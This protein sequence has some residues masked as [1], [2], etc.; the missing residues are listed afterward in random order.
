MPTVDSAIVAG[1]P[2]KRKPGRPPRTGWE[3]RYLKILAERG[4]TYL[5]AQ[6]AG[7]SHHTVQYRR[8][9][10]PEFVAAERD[11]IQLFAD[12]VEER[13]LKQADD[14]GNPV[15]YIVRLKA[16]RPNEYIE[17]QASTN[18]TLNVEHFQIV[19]AQAVAALTAFARAA[20]SAT[21]QALEA[22]AGE[23]EVT[24]R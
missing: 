9:R 14:R 3:A 10:D 18:I 8:E 19:E 1:R 7:V 15:G 24:P 22:H 13:M 6:A 17:K 12:G 21:I 11:A 4:G 16:L 2:N 20:S 23:T 5:S